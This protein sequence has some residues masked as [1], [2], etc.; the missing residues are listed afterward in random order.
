M[1]GGRPSKYNSEILEKAQY[2]LDNF[3]EYEDVIPSIAGLSLALDIA[4]STIY[5]WGS[6]PQKK[7][8]SEILAKIIDKQHNVLIQQGLVGEFNS[9]IAKLVLGKHGYKERSETDQNI[10]FHEKTIDDLE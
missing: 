3:K 1:P 10:T 2:Y 6:Q 7:E 8:F 4:S 5:D 9:N